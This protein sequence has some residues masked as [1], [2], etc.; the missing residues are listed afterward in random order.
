MPKAGSAAGRNVII[1]GQR[2]NSAYR[3]YNRL[4]AHDIC[5]GKLKWHLGGPADQFALPLAETFFLGPPLPLMDRLYVL[6]EAKGEIRLFALD[7]ASGEVA[8]SQ[9]VAV[10]ERD[11]LLDPMRRLAGASP[12]YADGILVCPTSTGAVVALDLATRS[13]LWGYRYGRRDHLTRHAGVFGIVPGRYSVADAR[14]RWAD[15][16]LTIVDGRVLLTPIESDELH[17]LNLVDGSLLWKQPRQDDLFV[18][19]VHD[20][21]VVL[22]GG[23]A[24]R[25][26]CLD[27]VD[28]HGRPKPAWDGRTV[29]LPENAMPSGR[30]FFN[31]QQ[32][33]LPL[34]TAEVAAIDPA[35]GQI[36]QVVKSR[37]GTVPGNLVCYN[38]RV[39]S[40]GLDGVEMYYQLQAAQREAA[41]R[42]ATDPDDPIGLALRGEV[43]L[44]EGNRSEAIACLHRCYELSDMPRTRILLREALF[45]GL[46]HEF[47][48]HR[49]RV[50][51]IE[52]LL[53]D[54]KQR[55]TYLRLMATGLQRSG[56]W[57]SALDYYLRLAGQD[58]DGPP[59]EEIDKAWTVRRDRWIQ[60]RLA[61]LRQ[62]AGDEVASLDAPI[63]ARL[64]AAMA[65]GGVTA[66]RS[67]LNYFGNQPAA[68]QAR[69]ELIRRLTDDGKLLEVEMMLWR[70][71]KSSDPATSGAATAELAEL[72]CRAKRFED[73][74]ACY[75]RLAGEFS[76]TICR[77]GKTGKQLLDALADDHPVRQNLCLLDEDPWPTGKVKDKPSVP[78]GPRTSSY[79][80]FALPLRGDGDEFFRETP[81]EYD[82]NNRRVIGHDPLGRERWQV[83]LNKSGSRASMPFNRTLTHGRAQ[84]HFLVLATGYKIIALDTL[85]PPGAAQSEPLWQEDLSNP[86]LNALHLARFP[87][88]LANMPWGIQQFHL[89]QYRSVQSSSGV[90]VNCEYVCFQRRRNL[91]AVEPI[92][93]RELWIRRGVEAGSTL[94]GNDRFIF[95]LGPQAKEALV[96]RALDG[97]LLGRRKLPRREQQLTLPDGKK[98]TVLVPFNQSCLAAIGAQ[99]L[100]WEQKGARS[101]LR[102]LDVWGQK[103]AWPPRTFAAGAKICL[104]GHRAAGVLQRDGKFVL[105]SLADG[106]KLFEAELEPEENLS[107][108][109]VIPSGDDYLV[110]T[111][112]PPHDVGPTPRS[113]QP[114]ATTLFKPIS[115]GRVYMFD[116]RGRAKWPQP[117]SIKDQHLLLNQPGRLPLMI[118]ACQVSDPRRTGASRY[119]AEI[120]CVDKRTGRIAYTGSFSTPTSNLDI[121]GDPQKKTIQLTMNRHAVTLTLTDQPDTGPT[122]LEALKKAVRKAV[123]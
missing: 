45:D 66:L 46:R 25:A 85:G 58:G 106:R 16:S 33:F 28:E 82:Q 26:V 54:S 21:K 4:A 96:F 6:G 80:R 123:E 105:L 88:Q 89:S 62:E 101:E 35:A 112:N 71:Y 24:V 115:R 83:M 70:D 27:K 111:H 78:K 23:K 53:D 22:V 74:A 42:L 92:G 81:L 1:G 8:W 104:V 68:A 63:E 77:Q 30:G 41:R 97:Q 100:L 109:F 49:D 19:C 13:L 73:A 36:V 91:V 114:I 116:G 10:A 108:L 15:G 60:A 118:F 12:S 99:V 39:I 103:D 2:I 7:A 119:R 47:A 79:G 75:R 32:Y 102:L 94:F 17:C 98:Q 87:I 76:E 107:E 18:A 31:G 5:T 44:D 40:Q 37:N 65:A 51:E 50:A 95:A 14:Q 11:I 9:Q 64:K 110:V 121:V 86:G 48:S 113:I 122:T 38:G 84:G 3:P 72:L 52:T 55:A 34:S 29:V 56:E 93:G 69:C 67:F 59:L 43:L 57:A 20:S 120:L 117:V 90:L 61:S